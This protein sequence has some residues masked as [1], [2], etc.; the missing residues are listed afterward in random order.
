VFTSAALMRESVIV[1]L[2]ESVKEQK[3][4]DCSE[5]EQYDR[6]ENK[7]QPFSFVLREIASFAHKKSCC[8]RSRAFPRLKKRGSIEALMF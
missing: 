6:R 7:R 4:R 5:R 2:L 1:D 3:E 8:R